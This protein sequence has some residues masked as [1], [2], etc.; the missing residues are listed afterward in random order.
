MTIQEMG[1]A[2]GKV[3]YVGGSTSGQLDALTDVG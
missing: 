2:E 1:G 3:A